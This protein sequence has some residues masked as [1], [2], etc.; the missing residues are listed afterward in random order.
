MPFNVN[1]SRHTSLNNLLGCLG[2]S[3]GV[4]WFLLVSVVVLNCPE[5]PRGGIVSIWV[6]CMYVYGVWMCV[7]ELW[8]FHALYG[9]ANALYWKCLKRQN[10]TYLTLLK[11]QN[12]KTSLYKLSK[13][14]W[15]ITLLE[16]FGSVRR[17]LQSTVS[18][19]HP[20]PVVATQMEYCGPNRS[21]FWPSND[22]FRGEK[23]I[24]GTILGLKTACF[25]HVNGLQGGTKGPKM[26]Q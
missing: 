2:P 20:V 8:S 10:S 15:V 4:C 19:D 9:A 11:H 21:Q 22:H 24:F 14:H 3:L 12:T 26:G 17:E 13:N 25:A 7:R 1:M 18:L 16:S 23:A 5:I 6:K